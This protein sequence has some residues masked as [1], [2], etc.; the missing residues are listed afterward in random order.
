MFIGS[1]SMMATAFFQR[2]ESIV[3]V[4]KAR[5]DRP[6]C[7]RILLITGD[8]SMTVKIF[9]VSAQHETCSGSHYKRCWIQVLTVCYRGE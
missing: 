2:K 8:S 7:V 1:A 4:I 9:N 3:E 6:R 5:V